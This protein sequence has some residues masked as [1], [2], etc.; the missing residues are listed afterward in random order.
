MQSSRVAECVPYQKDIL[1]DHGTD[2]ANE[3]Q[4]FVEEH[5]G[6]A[7]QTP[8]EHAFQVATDRL[9]VEQPC[10]RA[11]EKRPTEAS[12]VRTLRRA[13]RWPDCFLPVPLSCDARHTSPRPRI[14]GAS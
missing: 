8:R 12:T 5:A 11:R 1:R 7:L 3:R 14:K 9:V 4:R 2:A 6:V 10:R 13:A